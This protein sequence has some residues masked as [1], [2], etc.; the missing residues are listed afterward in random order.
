MTEERAREIERKVIYS[1]LDLFTTGNAG[2]E[3]DYL[4]YVGRGLGIIQE[5]LKRELELEINKASSDN[6]KILIRLRDEIV[7]RY[8]DLDKIDIINLI[9]KYAGDE[10]ERFIRENDKL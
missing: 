8:K 1:N 10:E 7:S 9:N 4:F 6:L 5:C 3:E 2:V